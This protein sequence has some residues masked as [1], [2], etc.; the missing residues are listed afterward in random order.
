MFIFLAIGIDSGRATSVQTDMQN[1]A[2]AAALAAA[3]EI[4]Y[5]IRDAGENA[6]DANGVAIDATSYAVSSARQVAYDVA[7]HNGFYIDKQRDVVFGQRRYDAQSDSWPITW[8]S[9]PYNTV[10]V[11]VRKTNPDPKA[12]DAELRTTFGWAVGRPSLPLETSS[13]AMIESRDIVLTMDFSRSMN[14]DSKLSTD[15]MTGSLDRQNNVIASL[16]AMWNALRTA[17]PKWPGTNESKFP[18]AG[19]GKI[20]SYVG[21]TITSVQKVDSKGKTYTDTNPTATDIYTALNLTGVAFPQ[22]GRN[23][24][25]LG[26]PKSKPSSSTSQSRWISYITWVKSSSSGATY[27]DLHS[28]YRH[29]YGYRTLM[30]YLLQQYY[31]AADSED[32]WRTPHYPFHAVK[33]GATLLTEFLSELDFGD[34]LGI[35]SYGSVSRV[36]KVVNDGVVNIDISADPITNQYSVINTIQRHKQAAEYSSGTGMGYG[37]KD[38]RQLLLGNPSVANDRGYMRNGSLPTLIVMTDGQ[39]NVAPTNWSLPSGFSWAKYTDYDGDG[40]ANY[41]TND[42]AK[43]YAFWEATEAVRRGCVIHTMCVGFDADTDLMRA[44]AFAGNGEYINVPGGTTTAA[45]EEDVLRAFARIASRVPPS[46]LIY[47]DL[48]DGN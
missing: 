11:Y 13:A 23:N 47:E 28:S 24:S 35:V 29:K 38:A 34:E 3:Q 46:K 4:V 14:F 15:N 18:A 32:L 33:G 41:S 25:G 8:G 26:L 44:I 20:N 10:K 17:N 2:D 6:T 37:I 36:E 9:Q 43:Q 7:Q 45:M 42:V 40:K 12:Q 48:Q 31:H 16:D 22:A 1:S 19:F 5:A 21:T 27:D 30:S 39:T